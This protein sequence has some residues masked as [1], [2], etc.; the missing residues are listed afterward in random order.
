MPKQKT[1]KNNVRKLTRSGRKGRS[2]GLT[3]P[4]EL[5]N[6]LGWKER[7]KVVVKKIGRKLVVKDWK[8]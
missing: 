8:K 1:K 2:L 7:Q 3:I 5:V 4:I 6:S